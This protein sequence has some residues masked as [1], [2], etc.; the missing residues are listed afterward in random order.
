LQYF[1]HALSWDLLSSGMLTFLGCIVSAGVGIAY[2]TNAGI[3]YIAY[4]LVMTNSSPWYRW[5]I[6]ADGLPNLKMV[7][8]H[9]YVSHNQMVYI[10]NIPN[11]RYSPER[12]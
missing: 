6:E 11:S 5:P 1:Q 9:G 12:L 8:F 4:P 3:A 10:Y 2:F 7:I